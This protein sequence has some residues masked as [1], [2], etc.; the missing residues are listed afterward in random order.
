MK[1][2]YICG[3]VASGKGLL[4]PLLDGHHM[5]TT[6]PQQGLGLSLISQKFISFVKRKRL[7]ASEKQKNQKSIKKIELVINTESFTVTVGEIISFLNKNDTLN[8]FIDNCI[9]KI[10][11]AGS[12][13]DNQRYINFDFNYFDFLK[14]FCKRLSNITYPLRLEELQNLLFQ[15]FLE[16]WKNNKS[17]YT[18]NSYFIQ[19]AS[20]GLV[21]IMDILENN[22]NS[23]I[24]IVMRDPVALSYTN[25]E[26]IRTKFKNFTRDQKFLFEQCLFDLKYINKIK[27]FQKEVTSLLQKNNDRIYLI[28]FEELVLKTE[29]T[30]SQVA[31]FLE[32]NIEDSLYTA[33]LNKEPL[34]TDSMKFTGKINDDPYENLNKS[35]ILLLKYLYG[36][37]ID[38]LS[39]IELISIKFNA[40]KWKAI[41]KYLIL[42]NKIK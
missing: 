30:M 40:L 31:N 17:T 23:K 2:V 10:I 36:E 24:I 25:T 9:G 27:S 5:I 12:S 28:K 19:S 22:K 26:R 11:V 7:L 20:N 18:D 38:K 21:P 41:N 35:Q 32:I 6:C 14:L 34:E 4:R 1:K 33:T 3:I 39:I 8:S 29:E 16:C 37:K 42:K 15:V 13:Q